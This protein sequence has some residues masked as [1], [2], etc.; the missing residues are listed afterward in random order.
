M[1]AHDLKKNGLV[2][3]SAIDSMLD[4]VI[5]TKNGKDFVK[6]LRSLF[7]DYE[8]RMG[9]QLDP[10]RVAGIAQPLA[11]HFLLL[12]SIPMSIY[13]ALVPLLDL[14]LP[15][16]QRQLDSTSGSDASGFD[17]FSSSDIDTMFDC[18]SSFADACAD[19]GG[20]D[21]DSGDS[22]DSGCSGCSGCGGCGGD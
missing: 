9:K 14:S 2:N 15:I 7:N 20:A 10:Q 4:H 13:P 6:R 18:D 22:V 11:T 21:S 1:T 12:E 17:T 3:D 19:G 5:L 8:S 16:E